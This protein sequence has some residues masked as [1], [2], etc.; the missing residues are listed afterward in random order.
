MVW[1]F[2]LLP[3]HIGRCLWAVLPRI[4]PSSSLLSPGININAVTPRRLLIIAA[5]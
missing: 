5:C 4:A 3:Y 1:S 2:Q